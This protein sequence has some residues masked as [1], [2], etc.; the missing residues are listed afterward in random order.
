MKSKSVDY[1]LLWYYYLNSPRTADVLSSK[2]FDAWE[3]KK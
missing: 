3:M 1:V 2:E